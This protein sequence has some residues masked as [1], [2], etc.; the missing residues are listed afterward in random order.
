MT[1]RYRGGAGEGEPPR[2]APPNLRKGM[3]TGEG[4]PPVAPPPRREDGN[5]AQ[6]EPATGESSNRRGTPGL[7]EPPTLHLGDQVRE[8]GQP[9]PLVG[10][11]T[12]DERQK[13]AES[14]GGGVGDLLAVS[15]SRLSRYQQCGE[16]FR[17]QHVVEVPTM[18]MG[19]AIAGTVCHELIEEMTLEGWF[20]SPDT[21][22]ANAIVEFEKRFTS[23]LVKEGG[24]PL[25][26]DGKL[27]DFD[28]I[29]WGGR[30]RAQRD[31][32]DKIV[33][34]AEGKSIMVGENYPWFLRMAPTWLKRAGTI[35]RE[36]ES[37]GLTVAQ[38]NVERRVT[39]WLIQPHTDPNYPEGVLV[40]GII[41]LM[42][43]TAQDGSHVIRDWKTGTYVNP[44]QLA[45]YAW[46][47][48]NIDHEPDRVEVKYGQIGYLRGKTKDTWIREYDLRPWVN[49][50]PR[51]FKEMVAGVD[52]G[53]FPLHP[54]SWCGSCW[55]REHC[56]YGVTLG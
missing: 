31:D 12:H 22:E 56:D 15:Y 29:Y 26:V 55:V 43:L 40:T 27:M 51:M 11:L 7:T 3:V 35:L 24:E 47:L 32:N 14:H 5:R 42:L 9:A 10:G 38:A 8:G 36:D 34:D 53:L 20:R 6:G 30:K 48:A 52:A 2:K 28:G 23:G 39:A 21:V 44:I 37:R 33:R 13:L 16:A 45:D 19:S 49:L 1:E 18:P 46:L 50:I 25:Y 17:L 4:D 54:S 41:D